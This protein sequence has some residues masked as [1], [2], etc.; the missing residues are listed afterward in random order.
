VTLL[1]LGRGLGCGLADLD[2]LDGVPGALLHERVFTRVHE[3]EARMARERVDF[4]RVVYVRVE[5]KH[6]PAA[7]LQTARRHREQDAVDLVDAV[8]LFIWKICQRVLRRRARAC[9]LRG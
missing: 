8:R 9:F 4:G 2:H 1:L 5:Q 6:Q 3:L 7:E